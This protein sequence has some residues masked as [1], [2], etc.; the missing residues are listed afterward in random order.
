MMD[1]FYS[2]FVLLS[3][4]MISCGGVISTR[5]VVYYVIYGNLNRTLCFLTP[6]S[7]AG[8]YR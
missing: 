1:M 4:R 6:E 8:Q 7:V 2:I 3:P 5:R